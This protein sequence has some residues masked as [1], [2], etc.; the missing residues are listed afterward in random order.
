DA[1][2]DHAV[3]EALASQ[4]R[5]EHRRVRLL[6]RDA[7]PGRQAVAERG[8]DVVGGGRRRR[9]EQEEDDRQRAEEPHAQSVV[10]EGC[11]SRSETLPRV[12][13]AAGARP[14]SWT[15]SRSASTRARRWPSPGPRE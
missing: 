4:A 14:A 9:D 3:L 10:W 8:D 12:C 7:E 15:A 5:L 6:G 11:S 13:R 1:G 2:V